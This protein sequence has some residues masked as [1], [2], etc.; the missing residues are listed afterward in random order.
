M[1]EAHDVFDWWKQQMGV[2]AM[3]GLLLGI[4]VLGQWGP[5]AFKLLS[6]ALFHTKL[7]WDRRQ[8]RKLMV[9]L[10]EELRKTPSLELVAS[11]LEYHDT[12]SHEQQIW[13]SSPEADYLASIL[14]EARNKVYSR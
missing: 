2:P 9:A 7:A 6:V 4:A 11:Q 1:R 10:E 13:F 12:R 14:L 8:M 3:Q 5:A